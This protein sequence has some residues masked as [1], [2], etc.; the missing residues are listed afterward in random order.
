MKWNSIV[1]LKYYIFHGVKKG[2]CS[3]PTFFSVYLNG[4]IEKL[5][6]QYLLQIW[7]EIYEMYLVM[8]TIILHVCLSDHKILLKKSEL[9]HFIKYSNLQLAIYLVVVQQ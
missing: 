8:Q 6:K 7:L 2:G 4:F 3:L 1:S 5:G 9:F